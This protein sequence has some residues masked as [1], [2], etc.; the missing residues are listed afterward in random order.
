MF[1]GNTHTSSLQDL[2]VRLSFNI[3]NDV[4]SD[5]Y[6]VNTTPYVSKLPSGV[7]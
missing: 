5:K 2:Y 1:A 3:P 6:V 4:N 7:A